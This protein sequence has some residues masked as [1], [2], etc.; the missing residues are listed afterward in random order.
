M[1]NK[2]SSLELLCCA[3][4]VA[5]TWLAEIYCILAASH[6]P[7]WEPLIYGCSASKHSWA[8]LQVALG[9]LIT[10]NGEYLS[11]V[12]VSR[13]SSSWAGCFEQG[14]KFCLEPQNLFLGSVFYF[15]AKLAFY[16]LRCSKGILDFLLGNRWIS[17]YYSSK[18]IETTVELW[19]A[20]SWVKRYIWNCTWY[21]HWTLYPENSCFKNYF[22]HYFI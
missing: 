19:V 4:A 14:C 15:S 13:A 11:G 5:L 22:P 10:F 7:D 3:F 18:A 21:N 1:F 9:S 8:Q 20:K 6:L 16:I 2:S 17:R 12:S